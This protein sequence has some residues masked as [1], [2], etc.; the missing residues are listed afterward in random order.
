MIDRDNNG[1]LD[2]CEQCGAGGGF[3]WSGLK[4]SGRC[5]ECANSTEACEYKFEAMILWNKDQRFEKKRKG[6]GCETD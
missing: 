2:K 4:W 5:T 3:Y 1:I 6:G